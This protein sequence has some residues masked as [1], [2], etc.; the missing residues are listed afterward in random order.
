[1]VIELG[2][3]PGITHD[4]S[5]FVKNNEATRAQ[6]GTRGKATVGQ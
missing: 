5:R 3:I 1:M 6:H 4:T 2:E